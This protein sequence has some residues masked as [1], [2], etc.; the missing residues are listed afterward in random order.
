MKCSLGISNYFEETSSLPH[1]VVFL[2]FFALI[3]GEGFLI[4][5]CYSL[6]LCI[7]MTISFHFV[8]AFCSSFHSYSIRETQLIV[9]ISKYV[10]LCYWNISRVQK[11]HWRIINTQ[12]I[13]LDLTIFP[14][15]F[16]D[17]FKEITFTKRNMFLWIIFE[18]SLFSSVVMVLSYFT[19]FT[20][21][22]P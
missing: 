12:Q 20:V 4:F 17:I 7:Q 8:F 19:I 22:C 6:E 1:S 13:S 3:A 2:Y 15:F 14:I 18:I 9:I 21:Y 11:L 5:S 10:L 16:S